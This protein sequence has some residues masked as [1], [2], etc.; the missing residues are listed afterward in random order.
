MSTLQI[1]ETTTHHVDSE[2]ELPSKRAKRQPRS[3]PIND[4][5]EDPESIAIAD[6]RI[7]ETVM[8]EI[9]EESL[10]GALSPDVD[11]DAEL[12]SRSRTKDKKPGNYDQCY[13]SMDFS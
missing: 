5:N 13:T 7:Q 6:S 10:S 1:G 2:A 3:V 4:E 8:A 12:G 11:D 9:T